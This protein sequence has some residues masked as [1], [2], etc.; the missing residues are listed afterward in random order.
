MGLT[1]VAI[2]ELRAIVA[3]AQATKEKQTDHALLT[4]MTP[5]DSLKWRYSCSCFAVR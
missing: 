3:S 5:K 4:Q 1:P 2:D